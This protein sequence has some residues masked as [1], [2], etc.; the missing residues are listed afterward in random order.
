MA[1]KRILL[2]NSEPPVQEVL[3]ESL[4]HFGGWQILGASSPS[5]GLRLATHDPPDAVIFDL[6]TFGMSFFSFLQKLRSQAAP[7]PLPVVLIAAGEKWFQAHN[8]KEFQ[9]V[10]V[11]SDVSDPVNFSRQVARLLNWTVD[12]DKYIV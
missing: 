1:T 6:S 11:I 8:F 9:V 7:Q 2:I 10:G 12:G 4:S 5:E 3:A